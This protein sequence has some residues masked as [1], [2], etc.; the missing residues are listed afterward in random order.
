MKIGL[1]FEDFGFSNLDLRYPENGNQ[2]IGGTEFTFLMLMRYLKI[3]K[4]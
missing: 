1:L 3:S 4:R 2:G